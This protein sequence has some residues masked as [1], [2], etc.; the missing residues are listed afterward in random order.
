MSDDDEEQVDGDTNMFDSGLDV[1][2]SM[3]FGLPT[4][5]ECSLM[6]WVRQELKHELKQSCKQCLRR[7][8]LQGQAPTAF[9]DMKVVGLADAIEGRV[10]VILHNGQ[11]WLRDLKLIYTITLQFF[12]GEIATQR[13]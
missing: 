13:I 2:D 5:I 6:E 4:E 12:F 10:N 11:G 3:G 9:Q 7:Y 1:S 8:V